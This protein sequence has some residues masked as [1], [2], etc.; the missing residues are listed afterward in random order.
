MPKKKK[1]KKADVAREVIERLPMLIEPA[2]S[3]AGR[4]FEKLHEKME[5]VVNDG[6]P[7]DVAEAQIATEIRAH[8]ARSEA[9]AMVALKLFVLQKSANERSTSRNVQ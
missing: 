1:R 6:K 7:K 8:I 2:Q 4:R 3:T 5:A 9:P